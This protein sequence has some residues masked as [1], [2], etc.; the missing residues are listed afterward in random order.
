MPTI[1]ARMMKPIVRIMGKQLSTG[2]S[3]SA[4]RSAYNR[5]SKTLLRPNGVKSETLN[6]AGQTCLKSTPRHAKTDCVLIYFH[7]GGYVFGSLAGHRSLAERF[8]K[9]TGL[10]T[11]MPDYR[12]APE[13]PYPAAVDDARAVYEE[14][15]KSYDASKIAI[16]G[17]SAG[18]GLS[19]ALMH[20]LRDE[21]RPLPS[22]AFLLS[23]W[24]DLTLQGGTYKSNA[25]TELVVPHPLPE[26]TAGF[27]AGDTPRDHPGI[28]PL[29]ASQAHLPPL[30]IQVSTNEILLDDAKGIVE[31]AKAEGTRVQYEPYDGMWH[32]WHM[33][34]PFIAESN[35][36]ISSI[37][38]FVQKHLI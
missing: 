31:K 7:G 11:Y 22:S 6:L 9:A 14:L 3:A 29:F 28:S 24:T 5:W 26:I 13:H 19:L 17:D 21:G 15:L 16:G 12:Q 30:L 25:A 33:M 36:A 38:Q 35:Q 1:R 8:A 37:G 20:Q 4:I 34:A 32:D 10:V 18:G 2:G 23:P 27:Y